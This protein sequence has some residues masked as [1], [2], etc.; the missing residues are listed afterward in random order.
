MNALNTLG[1]IHGLQTDPAFLTNT[2]SIVTV[3]VRTAETVCQ[4]LRGE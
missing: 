1:E 2:D 4:F 3:L